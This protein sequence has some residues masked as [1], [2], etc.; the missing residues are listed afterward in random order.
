MWDLY[1]VG[2]LLMEKKKGINYR[3]GLGKVFKEA[4]K[5]SCYELQNGGRQW[6]EFV[7]R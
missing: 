6:K 3:L 1:Y 4:F 2:L 7:L 5:N